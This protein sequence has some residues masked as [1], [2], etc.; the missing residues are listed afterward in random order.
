MLPGREGGASP[1]R[2]GLALEIPLR[3]DFDGPFG[4]VLIL[5]W[6]LFIADQAIDPLVGDEDLQLVLAGPSSIGNVHPERRL[7]QQA[8][9]FAIHANLRYHVHPAQVQV[10][11][12]VAGCSAVR[13][14]YLLAIGCRP[15]KVFHARVGVL[16]QRDQFGQRHLRRRAEVGREADLPRS[17]NLHGLANSRNLQG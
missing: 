7:P 6:Q 11:P 15:G 3:Y 4:R 14:A 10:Q 5:G 17:R 8:N 2:L 9:I 13:N 12:T 16:V 1:R